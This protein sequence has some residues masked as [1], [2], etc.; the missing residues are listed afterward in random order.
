M[1]LKDVV[2]FFKVTSAGYEPLHGLTP[3]DYSYGH[4]TKMVIGNEE[5]EL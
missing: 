1:I 5:V 2:R 4:D 3:G